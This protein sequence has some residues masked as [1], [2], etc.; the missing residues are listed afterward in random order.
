MK[1]KTKEKIKI[2]LNINMPELTF[3][4]LRALHWN[5]LYV[6]LHEY[7]VT[8]QLPEK[9]AS[10]LTRFKRVAKNFELDP[11]TQDIILITNIIPPEL[12]DPDGEPLVEI[13]LPLKFTVVD[14]RRKKDTIITCFNSV[15]SG[16]FK[17]VESLYRKIS[18]QYL[19]ISRNDI[20]DVLKKMELKQLKRPTLTREIKPIL[21]T[22][23]M[24][25]WQIDLVDFTKLGYEKFNDNY[26]FIL[27]IVDIFS[28]FVWSF[29]LKN[30]S[31]AVVAYTL[32]KLIL[33]EGS[34]SIIGSDNG[35][36]FSNQEM[37]S[38]ALTYSIGFRHGQPYKSNTQGGIER[39]NGTLRDSIFNY[40]QSA[41]T[42]RWIDKL[43]FF[44]YSYN[45]AFHSSIKVTLF[46]AH[47][48]RHEVFKIDKLVSANIEKVAPQRN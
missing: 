27:N 4:S 18:S 45:T 21:T 43:P 46:M 33:T 44:A 40:L 26:V 13:D 15:Q 47:R 41:L 19:G 22:R 29:P 42:K 39:V 17:G 6:P 3:K 10:S 35:T 20:A 23:P 36:E 16:G 8:G 48:R 32:Q 5:D 7:L 24:E 12:L 37:D 38:L 1:Q 2:L 9:T 31:G 34:P 28:K 11:S 14:P 25:Y 30:K